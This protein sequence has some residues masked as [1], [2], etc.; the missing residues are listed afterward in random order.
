VTWTSSI[1]LVDDPTEVGV[2]AGDD[3]HDEVTHPGDRVD[4]E[5]LGDRG[6]VRH[7]R[8]V[9]LPLPDLQGAERRHGIAQGRGSMVRGEGLDDPALL[10]PVEPG[11]HRAARHP[12]PAEAPST[13]T[14]GSLV[15]SSMIGRRE[16]PLRVH[17]S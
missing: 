12:Q 4:L 3:P 10:Q 5:H 15:K 16:H 9:A 1:D 14:W 13:P 7:D 6:Q 2:V 17:R 8:C 11:L